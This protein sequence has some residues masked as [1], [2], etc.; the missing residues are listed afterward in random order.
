[1]FAAALGW[2]G[3]AGTFLAYVMLWRGRL[4]SQSSRYALLNVVGGVLGGIASASYGAWPSTVSN[5]VWA[6]V[7]LHSA[8]RPV[9][10][11]YRRHRAVR[12]LVSH[13]A[14]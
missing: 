6:A 5:F 14:R 7:G 4:T 8:L 13:L 2:L 1:M 10:D 9:R 12:H 11:A 3:T